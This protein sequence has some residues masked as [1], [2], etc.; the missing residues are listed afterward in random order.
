MNIDNINDKVNSWAKSNSISVFSGF[1]DGKNFIKVTW[2]VQ[3]NYEDF[4]AVAKKYNIKVLVISKSF[5]KIEDE[6][7]IYLFENIEN[8]SLKRDIDTFYHDFKKLNGA[9]C[10]YLISWIKET[11]IYECPIWS[12][13]HTEFETRKLELTTKYPNDLIIQ[14]EKIRPIFNDLTNKNNLT[15]KKIK[16][17]AERLASHEDYYVMRYNPSLQ[18]AT[19]SELLESEDGVD[20]ID[21]PLRQQILNEASTVFEQKYILQREKEMQIRIS[22]LKQDGLTKSMIKAKLGLSDRQ[23]NKLWL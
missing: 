7:D 1:I 13:F 10:F 11:V 17:I 15:N 21:L 23:L 18:K 20:N 12:D 3:E 16:K 19:L 5:F 4:L 14:F 8:S 9:L 22:E 6:I 2:D